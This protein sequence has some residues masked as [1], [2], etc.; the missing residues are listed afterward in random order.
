[1]LEGKRINLRIIEKD[2][3]EIYH[4]WMNDVSFIGEFVFARQQS[5]TGIQK[6]FSEVSSKYAS[7]IVEKKDGSKIGVVHHFLS[8]LYYDIVEIGYMIIPEERGNGYCTEAIEII[9]DYLFILKDIHR[10]Q[11][12]IFEENIASQRIL[13]KT[14]FKKEGVIRNVGYGRGKY[15][16]GVLYSIIRKDWGQ[17][18]ILT[19]VRMD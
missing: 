2:D 9:V 18:R 11:A 8:K 7:F 4:Q 10:I 3:F 12:L 19:G 17:P 1:M 5:M 15:R 16:D 13:E 14:G 6:R